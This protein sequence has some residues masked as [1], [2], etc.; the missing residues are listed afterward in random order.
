MHTEHVQ[1]LALFHAG[2]L[3]GVAQWERDK[4]IWAVDAR[5]EYM[6]PAGISVVLFLSIHLQIL[7]LLFYRATLSF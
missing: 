4:E 5:Q 6:S 7:F 3:A 2:F 1:C